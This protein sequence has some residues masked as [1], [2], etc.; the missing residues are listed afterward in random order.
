M[1]AAEERIGLCRGAANVRGWG[2]MSGPPLPKQGPHYRSSQRNVRPTA[3][4]LATWAAIEG[5][6]LPVRS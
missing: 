5:S 6:R 2:A 3:A 1:S 4:L